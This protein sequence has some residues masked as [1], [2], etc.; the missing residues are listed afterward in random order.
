[1]EILQ[2]LKLNIG[3]AKGFSYRTVLGIDMRRGAMHCYNVPGDNIASV[4]HNIKHYVG[5]TF[6]E[7][8]FNKFNDALAGFVE[9]MP[10]A[11]T[12]KVAFVLP[13]EA[14]ALD[15]VR[16]PM[17]RSQ[18]LINNSLDAKLEEIFA[19]RE[20]LTV[21]TF[22]AEKNRQYCTYGVAA[23]QNRVLQGVNGALAKNKM[24]AD[25]VTFA[26]ASTVTAVAT[27]NPKWKN[28]TYLFL[29]IKDV[30][31]RFIFVAQGRAIGFYSLPFGRQFLDANKY[32]QEDMLFDH[33]LGELTVLNAKEKARAKKLSVLQGDDESMS[34]SVNI[35]AITMLNNDVDLDEE[36]PKPTEQSVAPVRVEDQ[37]KIMAKKTPRKLPMF[38]QRPIPE[39]EQDV[40]K[41]NF[42][43]FVKWALT[44]LQGNPRLTAFGMPK[45][46]CVNLP[47]TFDFVIDG[48]NEEERENGLP[49]VR[50]GFADDN[51]DLAQNLELYGGLYANNWHV[52]AKF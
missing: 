32:V 3:K 42:R 44:L 7:E 15:N 18:K 21:R 34:Q 46:V 24:L 27:L 40:M 31:S 39:E 8:F 4:E 13:D 6:D 20:D 48:V 17:L 12:R 50:F 52:S 49:F 22:L 38:M 36:L 51:E 35:E 45:F 25:V 11:E 16:L 14:V 2:G 43:V 26:S 41:E 33:S 30:Y 19:N 29:D 5:G 47:K 10:T 28:E 1:M 23:I 9:N 37:K